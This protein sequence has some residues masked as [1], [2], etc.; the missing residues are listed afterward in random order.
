MLIIASCSN[1]NDDNLEAKQENQLQD[2]IKT[3]VKIG[4]QVWM[5]S[6]LN[7]DKF[8]NGDLIPE[9]KSDEEWNEAA[10]NKTPAWCY[11]NNNP[12]NGD[13]YG[14][15]YNWYAISDP[16]G[17]APEGWKIPSKEDWIRLVDFLG[18][19]EPAGP[20]LRAKN[21]WPEDMIGTDEFEFNAL[22]SGSRGE[23]WRFGSDMG[24]MRLG[25]WTA[26]WTS[27]ISTDSYANGA[28]VFGL[29]A[30]YGGK[31]CWDS[32]FYKSHGFPVRCIKN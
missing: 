14:K 24:F 21:A 23:G 15:L 29:G 31:K 16:R 25:E 19:E 11:Y 26:F 20:K 28:Y 12:D 27:T 1:D 10:E 4:K 6:N 2:S 30:E 13:K 5:N 18:G 7:V 9:A 3:E 8:K 22:P 32:D 17:I